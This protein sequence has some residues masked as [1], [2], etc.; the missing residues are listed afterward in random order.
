[1]TAKAMTGVC[2]GPTGT[3][4]HR[5]EKDR[6]WGNSIAHVACLH[7]LCRQHPLDPRVIIEMWRAGY[8]ESWTCMT[9]VETKLRE[10]AREAKL[11]AE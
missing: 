11:F 9:F 2:H 6:K 10:C 5:Q 7:C 4:A 8:N 1:M 3:S